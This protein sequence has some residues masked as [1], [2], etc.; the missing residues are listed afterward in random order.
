MINMSFK[1]LFLWCILFCASSLSA[2]QTF[3]LEEAIDYAKTNSYKQQIAEKEVAKAKALVRETVGRGLPQVNGSIGYQKF[4]DVPVQLVPDF[5]G[6]TN[7]LIEVSFTPE[8]SMGIDITATQL[9]FDGTYIVGL[10][11]SK[12]VLNFSK[13]QAEKSWQ[14]VVGEVQQAYYTAL[15]S[16]QNAVTLNENAQSIE[17]LY[18]DTK[19]MFENG[20]AEESDMQQLEVNKNQLVNSAERASRLAEISESMLKLAIGMDM[21]EIITLTSTLSSEVSLASEVLQS[22]D[23][24][25]EDNL[26]F[27]LAEQ[28]VTLQH[29]SFKAEK[30]RMLPTLSAMASQ[31][32][33]AYSNTFTLLSG[34]R[35]FASSLIG[36][37]L[38]IP[39]WSSFSHTNTIKQAKLEF[40]KAE[41]QRTQ[42]EQGIMLEF[43]KH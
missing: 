23:F 4:L 14:D 28:N 19:A 7:E 10:Q 35:Y 21:S 33:N 24:A 15:V 42:A 1:T 18:T 40:E 25:I 16:K 6:Q 9:L 20:L 12:Q 2:Q 43:E 13:M 11:A 5:T 22:K 29:L 3:S 31:R 34:E 32:T 8:Y 26:N 36:I 38:S 37:N 27:Q 30:A 39:I 17:K 41:I